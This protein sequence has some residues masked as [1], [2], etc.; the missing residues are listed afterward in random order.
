MRELAVQP[1]NTN[2]LLGPEEVA[3]GPAGAGDRVGGRGGCKEEGGGSHV[4]ACL[5][6]TGTKTLRGEC[7][8]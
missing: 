1:I 7:G 2:I 5:P 3:A 4:P 8:S 6:D